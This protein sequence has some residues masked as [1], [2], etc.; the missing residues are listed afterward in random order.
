MEN[1][2]KKKPKTGG[3]LREEV[4]EQQIGENKNFL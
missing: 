1:N 3:E 4:I 2:T